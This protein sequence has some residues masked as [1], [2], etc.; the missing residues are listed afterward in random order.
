[1]R[2][3]MHGEQKMFDTVTGIFMD[4]I[5]ILTFQAGRAPPRRHGQAIVNPSDTDRV[6]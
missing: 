5:R 1:M 2:F 6:R 4:V 3:N